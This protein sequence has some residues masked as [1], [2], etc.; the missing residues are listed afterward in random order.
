MATAT[1]AIECAGLVRRYGARTAL[2]DVGFTIT[3]GSAVA[4]IGVNGAGKTTLLRGLLDLGRLDAGTVQIFGR[5]HL[6]PAARAALAYLPERLEPPAFARGD[7]WLRHLL[8]LHGRACDPAAAAAEA[9]ALELD[10]AALH[11]PLRTYS[12]GMAQKLGLIA[13]ILTGAPLLVLDEP[14]SG[15][16]PHAR[17]LFRRR[18]LALKAAGTTLF[19]S[20]HDLADA[21]QI[22]DRLLLLHAGRLVFDGGP[23]ALCEAHG[24]DTLEAAFLACI[25]A[26]LPA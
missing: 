20:T 12:K 18:L 4:L 6:Q 11:A 1:P 23:A 17:A 9:A 16:D 25:A 14:L 2:A 7:E 10:P 3:A 26:A 24:A 8:A 5:P 21:A 19:F 15:L 13:C 22:C